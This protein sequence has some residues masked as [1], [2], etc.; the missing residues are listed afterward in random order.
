MAKVFFPSCKNKISY[1]CASEKL[2][3]YLTA[4][5][6]VETVA[7]CCRND[8][9]KLSP[10]DT[11]VIVC[12]SCFAFCEESSSAGE[13]IS[14]WE[15]IDSDSK[16]PFPNYNEEKITVQDCW[17]ATG[18]NKIHD[19][20][21]SLLKK[22]NIEPVELNENRNKS[23]FCGMTTFMQLPVHSAELAPRRYGTDAVGI[24]NEYPEEDRISFMK[25][26]ARQFTTDRAVCYCTSCD[27]GINKGGKKPISLIN[28]LF[29]E[30]Q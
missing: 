4:S 10:E 3:E 15:I 27:I 8:H 6:G 28:L 7:G 22:M 26:H 9:K 23:I 1:P 30:A 17:R 21:R 5:Y 12:N 19:A 24:F 2:L 29:N 25:E 20:V 16:F 11:A 14:V 13:I 18:R